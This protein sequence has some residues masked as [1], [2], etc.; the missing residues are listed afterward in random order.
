MINEQVAEESLPQSSKNVVPGD[1]T[2]P[3]SIPATQDQSFS[4]QKQ[5]LHYAS[6]N[7]IMKS[8]SDLNQSKIDVNATLDQLNGDKSIENSSQNLVY[9]D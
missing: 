5:Q 4:M 3:S 8:K 7:N 1:M 9:D 2:Q 6:S